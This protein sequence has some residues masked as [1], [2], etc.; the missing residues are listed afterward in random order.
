MIV[1]ASTAKKFSA[2]GHKAFHAN[3]GRPDRLRI[4]RVFDFYP[5]LTV[6]SHRPFCMHLQDNEGTYEHD[7]HDGQY[8][9]FKHSM[10]END[11]SRVRK[12]RNFCGED[13]ALVPNL[14]RSEESG[15]NPD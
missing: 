14:V 7:H 5:L 6:G 12:L 4:V 8:S 3:R 10:S 2:T 9:Q 11:V 1:V 15:T 13:Q